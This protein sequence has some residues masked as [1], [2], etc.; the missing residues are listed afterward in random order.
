MT[1]E[2]SVPRAEC[3]K[4]RRAMPIQ[5]RISPSAMS[6]LQAALKAYCEAVENS[7]LS[8]SSHATYVDMVN[9]FVRWLRF[10]FEPGSR[11]APYSL[12]REKD[13][14]DFLT[15]VGP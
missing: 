9:T 15:F 3:V 5:T 14:I 7:D 1:Q 13:A 12:K 8:F 6:E 11:I 4:I 10:D 2:Q